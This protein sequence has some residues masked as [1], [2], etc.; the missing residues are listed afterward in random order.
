MRLLSGRPYRKGRPHGFRRIHRELAKADRFGPQITL[1]ILENVEGHAINMR[2]Q[3]LIAERG[4][5]N[6]PPFGKRV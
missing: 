2:E 6:D 5:L 3:E 1:I 4:G